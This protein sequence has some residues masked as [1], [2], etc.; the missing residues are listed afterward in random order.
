MEN[1]NIY[2]K[3]IQKWGGDTQVL[4]LFEEMA[5]LQNDICKYSRGRATALNIAEEIAD[6]EIMLEQMKVLFVIDSQVNKFR[7]DKIKRL[8]KLIKET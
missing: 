6:V 2:L 1:K 8:R 3:A 7:E 5:E 4:M